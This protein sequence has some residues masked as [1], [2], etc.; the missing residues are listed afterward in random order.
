MK[1]LAIA[2]VGFLFVMGCD[3]DV[4]PVDP[5]KQD[6]ELSLNHIWGSSAFELN[7][8]YTTSNGDSFK[9]TLLRY[10]INNFE[11]IDDQGG[12]HA[13]KNWELS[14]GIDQVLKFSD[15]TG[16]NFTKI[17]FTVGVA[18]SATNRNGLLNQEFVDPMYWAMASGY[19][20]VKLEGRSMQS[21]VE[22]GVYYHIGGYTSGFATARTIE[23]EF[24][25]SVKAS[26]GN[27]TASLNVDVAEF[28]T[29]PNA[30]DIMTMDDVQTVSADA[31]LISQNWDSMFSLG[32]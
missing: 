12:V 18:D 22:G 8:W 19:I 10:H 23:L 27:N 6:I 7:E 9:P 2:L 30:I 25:S 11:L 16:A 1:K 31:V 21:G 15:S 17:R 24:P 20:N 5:P 14:E 4:P 26:L 28:F 29:T 32:N 13:Y 3:D